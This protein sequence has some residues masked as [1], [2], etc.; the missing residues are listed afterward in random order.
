M[1]AH[2]CNY[3]IA[4]NFRQ[5]KISSKAT[6]RQFKSDRQAVGYEFI[7]VKHRSALVCSSVVR[8]IVALLIDVYF[9]IHDRI[10][11]IPHFRLVK[12]N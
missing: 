11:L 2:T 7:F 1:R 6:V 5:R 9:Y 3:N 10:F 8:S 12:T 4:G